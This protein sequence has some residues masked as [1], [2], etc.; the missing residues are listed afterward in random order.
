MSGAGSAPAGFTLLDSLIVVAILGIIGMVVIPQFQGVIQETKLNEAAGEIVT[1]LQYAANLA[2]HHGRPFGFQADEAGRWFKVYDSRYVADAA[3][4]HDQD[5]PVT[6]YGVVMNPL[7]KGW[8]LRD[9]GD[10]E[11]YRAVT[12]TGAQVVFYPD[13]HSGNGNATVTVSLG[14]RNRV[15][16]IDGVTGRVAVQ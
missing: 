4:H 7:D 16:T 5:P 14:G 2:V 6:S 13:G 12:F 3:S 11:G 9:V 15:I 8:Y 10:G 1:G